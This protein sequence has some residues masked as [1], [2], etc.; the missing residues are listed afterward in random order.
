MARL[1]AFV[2][3]AGVDVVAAGVAAGREAAATFAR[4]VVRFFMGACHGR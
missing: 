1:L 4:I 2:F 3:D